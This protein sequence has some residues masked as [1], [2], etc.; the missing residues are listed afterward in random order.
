MASRYASPAT[1]TCRHGPAGRRSR[2]GLAADDSDPGMPSGERPWAAAALRTAGLTFM[3]VLQAK[4][5]RSARG[6]RLHK[7]PQ[8]IEGLLMRGR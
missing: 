7:R 6:E 4:K 1:L 8:E 5:N 2:I 3:S